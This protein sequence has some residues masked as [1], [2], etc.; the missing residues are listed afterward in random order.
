MNRAS[1]Q[2]QT[3][4][5]SNKKESLVRSMDSL[6]RAIELSRS[7]E[8]AMTDVILSYGDSSP[9]TTF[10]QEEVRTL[11]AT[12][13]PWFTF[14]YRIFGFNSGTAK[15][16]NLLAQE[17]KADYLQLMNPDIIVSPRFFIDMMVPFA[18]STTKVGIVEARQTPIEH[19][20]EYDKHT[21]ETSW[22]TGAC[23]I[24]PTSLFHELEGYD[25][26]SFFMYCDDVDLS[27]R[28]R[29]L[30]YKI[31]Y[32]PLSPVYHSKHLGTNGSL[33]STSAEKQYSAEAALLMAHKWSN[34]VVL[35]KLLREFLYSNDAVLEKV[36]KDFSVKKSE[37][38]LPQPI[39]PEHL[40]ATY[41]G[42]EYTK[43]R[44]AL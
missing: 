11:A 42:Y 8:T 32:Q 35:K 21:G 12:Y 14:Q 44:F 9:L 31:I 16:H 2:V 1:I 15:G 22:A 4:L 29:L 39:D 34:P 19:P 24:I 18:R 23:S 33:Q 10:S 7:S 3:I 13:E 30:G 36:V 25:A 41:V 27:W 6:A 38:R 26:D 43:H 40:V 37:N 5:Y 20:K 17:C 28:V